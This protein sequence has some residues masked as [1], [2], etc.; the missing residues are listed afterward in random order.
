MRNF[1]V[2]V[3]VA[4]VI[5]GAFAGVPA[6]GA[7]ELPFGKKTA[8]TRVKAEKPAT[9]GV[10][11][12]VLEPRTSSSGAVKTFM[13]KKAD[14]KKKADA[15]LAAVKM[16]RLPAG[17]IMVGKDSGGS[18]L[19]PV[20]GEISSAFGYRRHPLRHHGGTRFHTGIDIRA[21]RG[22]PIRSAM[23]GTVT[24]SGWRN[25]YGLTV[26]IDHGNGYK[27]LYA[28]CS[29]TLVTK[30]MR[31]PRGMQIAQVG[32]TGV[33]TGCHLHYEV[34]RG[35]SLLDPVHFIR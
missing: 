23:A 18:F 7:V 35:S 5:S 34:R 19:C 12:G 14:Q 21:R 31:V 15:L 13:V 3:L 25:G 1:S 20:S 24:Y 30:G 27:T 28:H 6:F 2:L 17:E 32:S 22:T 26:E 10:F 8:E 16:P 4:L 33:A 11:F 29:R 9:G